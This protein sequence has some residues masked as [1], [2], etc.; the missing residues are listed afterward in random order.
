M[1][2][3]W[4]ALYPLPP[5]PQTKL[6][7]KVPKV[8]TGPFTYLKVWICHCIWG[9]SIEIAYWWH[10]TSTT[11]I[12]V[13]VLIGWS[14]FSTNQEHYLD[15]G[16]DASSVWNLY[17]CSSDFIFLGNRWW[18]VKCWLFSQAS[19]R[20]LVFAKNVSMAPKLIILSSFCLN[21]RNWN[22]KEKG[23]RRK[24]TSYKK[25]KWKRNGE[26]W[27]KNIWSVWGAQE[28]QVS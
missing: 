12:W 15:M 2:S 7:P 16:S 27:E 11:K 20:P 13:V 17:V 8:E 26:I 19:K 21:S 6:T 23:S 3:Q 25:M 10:V 14:K 18:R 28:D 4:P 1:T 5:P 24:E 9:T 22:W